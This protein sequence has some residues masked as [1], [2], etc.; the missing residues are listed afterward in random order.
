M[1]L[2][3]NDRKRK[4]TKPIKCQIVVLKSNNNTN[5]FSEMSLRDRENING[6]TKKS[7]EQQIAAAI[8]KTITGITNVCL[9]LLPPLQSKFQWSINDMVK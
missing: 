3:T 1:K 8:V 5:L 4:E 6:R 2:D 7:L 9:K